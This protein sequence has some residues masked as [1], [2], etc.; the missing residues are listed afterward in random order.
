[1]QFDQPDSGAKA[2]AKRVAET[3]RSAGENVAQTAKEQAADVAAE[4]KQQAASLLHTFRSEVGQQAGTQQSRIAEALHGLSDELGS[5]AS[6]SSESGPITQLAQEG[7]RRG[8]EIAH[9]LS[10]REPADVLDEVRRYASRRPMTFLALCG[11][12]GLVAGRLTRGIVATNTSLDSKSGDSSG[13]DYRTHSYGA[14][15]YA[16]DPLATAQPVNPLAAPH[17]GDPLAVDPRTTP[18]PGTATNTPPRGQAN[19]SGW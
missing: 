6:G 7:S 9:W 13:T 15:T 16:A 4:A 3:T 14:S 12:A 10:Q 2:E 1:V 17:Q 5:M 11:A 19:P 8:G 18:G